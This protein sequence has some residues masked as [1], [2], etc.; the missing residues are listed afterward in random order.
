M[1]VFHQPHTLRE[2]QAPAVY[3]RHF[4]RGRVDVRGIDA[5]AGKRPGAGQRD[6]SG[7]GTD[8]EDASHAPRVGPGFEAPLDEL[9]D[10]RAWHQHPL[11]DVE[12]EAREPRLVRE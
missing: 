2:T 7:A 12:F 1:V 8:V 6:T 9:G 3:G 4:E 10:G 5:S 11:V